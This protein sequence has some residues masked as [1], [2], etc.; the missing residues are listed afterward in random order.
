ME[1]SFRASRH[2][3]LVQSQQGAQASGKKLDIVLPEKVASY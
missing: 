3:Q 1:G 2:A